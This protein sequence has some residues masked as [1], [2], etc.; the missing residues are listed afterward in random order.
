LA[1]SHKLDSWPLDEGP[2]PNSE[3]LQLNLHRHHFA[4]KINQFSSFKKNAH[5][6][7]HVLENQDSS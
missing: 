6:R 3:K 7:A 4:G 2:R 1:E 5:R